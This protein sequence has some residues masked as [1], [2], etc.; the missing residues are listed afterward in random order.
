MKWL[1]LFITFPFYS[2]VLHHQMI[3]AQGKSVTLPNKMSVSQTIGQ[4]SVAGTTTNGLTIQQG[5]QQSYWSK[6][7]SKTTL[8]EELKV[9]TYPNPFVT[10]V[11][12][13]FSKPIDEPISIFVFDIRGRLIIQKQENGFNAILTLDLSQLPNSEYLVRLSATNFNYYTKIIKSL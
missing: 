5:F 11:N 8:P 2:Q 12:F 7:I 13:Q 1:I 6:L 3:S 9:T 10:L 4:Q